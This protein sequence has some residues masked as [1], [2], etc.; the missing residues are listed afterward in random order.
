LRGVNEAPHLAKDEFP[1]SFFEEE[2]TQY[3]V[4]EIEEWSKRSRRGEGIAVSFEHA[5]IMIETCREVAKER[6]FPHPGFAGD[7]NQ[8]TLPC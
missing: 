1:R 6:C 4:V 5:H 3:W 2:T 8:A 7:E